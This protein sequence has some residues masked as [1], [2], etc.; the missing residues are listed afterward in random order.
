[1]DVEEIYQVLYKSLDI[2]SSE[3]IS[4]NSAN[5]NE[6]EREI[7]RRMLTE[8]DRFIPVVDNE[9]DMHL[10]FVVKVTELQQ[11]LQIHAVLDIPLLLF[12]FLVYF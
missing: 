7:E 8:K 2:N 12:H 5:V 6:R 10:L 1:M 11:Y 3:K 9:R 4:N